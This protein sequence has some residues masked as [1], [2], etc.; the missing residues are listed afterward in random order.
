MIKVVTAKEMKGLE[1][2]SLNYGMSYR[3]LMENAGN[4]AADFLKGHMDLE[5]KRCLIFAGK[6]NNGGDSFVIVRRILEAGAHVVVALTDG[7]PVTEEASGTL[8]EAKELG[9]LIFEYDQVKDRIEQLASAVDLV[10]DGVY[11]TGFRGELD[12]KHKEIFELINGSTGAVVALDLPS[13]VEADTGRA[14]NGAV[15]ADI[16]LAFEC[17]KPGHLIEPGRSFCG[18]VTELPI[19]I[20]EE[21]WEEASITVTGMEEADVFR[22]LK[23]RDPNGHKGSFGKFLNVGGSL[24]LTGAAVLSTTAALRSGAGYVT[25]AAPKSVLYALAPRLIESTMLPLPE[26]EEGTL[27]EQ[28]VPV[29]LERAKKCTA[30]LVGC[31][32][33]RTQAGMELV[34]ALLRTVEAPLVLDADALSLLAGN[35]ELLRE[36]K[37]PVILTPH[38]VEMARLCG[39]RLADVQ[40]NRLETAKSFAKEYGVIVLLKG[41]DTI[42]T[43]G[44]RVCINLT[45]NAGMAKAGSGDVLAGMIGA[46]AAQK[47][48]PMLAAVCGAYLHGAAGDRCAKRLSQYGMLPLDMIE[49]LCGIFVENGR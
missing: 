39:K 47:V 23:E 14:A 36:R 16:T 1:E 2:G 38:P 43:N 24:G 12:Q 13:G 11:G 7:Y 40:Q 34:A 3:G 42:I 9:A 21:C 31:G 4:A 25:L 35:T 46:F 41:P 20:P 19:G 27:S 32:L 6:G 8:V 22:V 48:P 29:V 49:D 37:G 26:T 33:G 44:D 17:R 28:A 15:K 30:V 18:S 10:V 45:G 5:E